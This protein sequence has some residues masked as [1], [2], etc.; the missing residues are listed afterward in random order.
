MSSKFR[1]SWMRT[2]CQTELE[3]SIDACVLCYPTQQDQS[4]EFGCAS[5][6]QHWWRV[7]AAGYGVLG[8]RAC[9]LGAWEGLLVPAMTNAG[10]G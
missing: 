5:C 1:W 8:S 3:H 2:G 6:R 7:L 10:D 9:S 4:G